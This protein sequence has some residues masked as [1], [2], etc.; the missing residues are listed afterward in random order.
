[1]Q[2][3]TVIRTSKNQIPYLSTVAGRKFGGRKTSEAT[4]NDGFSLPDRGVRVTENDA[5]EI[6]RCRG[7][8][9]ADAGVCLSV[10]LEAA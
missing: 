10:K 2:V 5:R 4:E 3:E 6:R 1:M 7:N 9:R 8:E